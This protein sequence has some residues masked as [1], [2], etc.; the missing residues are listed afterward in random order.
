MSDNAHEWRPPPNCSCLG[1]SGIHIWRGRYCFNL[2]QARIFESYL[3]EEEALRIGRLI[4]ASDRERYVFAHGM[5]RS[6][7]GYYI[8][9]SPR[10]IVFK[11]NAFGKPSLSGSEE[12]GSIHFNM[13]HSGDVVLLALCRQSD[14]GI[15][16]EKIRDIPKI[17]QMIDHNF[18]SEERGYLH[19]LPVNRLRESFFAQWV[20]KESFIKGLGVGLSYPLQD[21]T[22]KPEINKGEVT[23]RYNVLPKSGPYWQCQLFAPFPGYV[24]AVAAQDIFEAPNLWNY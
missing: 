2:S 14:I 6:V 16:V 4:R 10:D 23:N 17:Y 15:D 11:F 20:L 21:F 7:I 19:N 3:S 24:G 22:I 18:S 5:L 12:P 9:C 8:G 13:A 1:P